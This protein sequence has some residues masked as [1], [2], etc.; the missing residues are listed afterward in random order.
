MRE[1]CVLLVANQ[2]AAEKKSKKRR[3]LFGLDFLLN[4][5]FHDCL[6]KSPPKK[7]FPGEYFG[8]AL[9]CFPRVFDIPLPRNAQERTYALFLVSWRRCT[10]GCRYFVSFRP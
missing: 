5:R 10:S 8:N 7:C 1:C 9:N 3:T 4:V 2:G 6:K